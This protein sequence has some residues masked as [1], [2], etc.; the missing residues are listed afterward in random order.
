[1]Y[2]IIII[3]T[4]QVHGIQTKKIKQIKT[5][6][7]FFSHEPVGTKQVCITSNNYKELLT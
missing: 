5:K 4:L 6:Y 1:M 7:S 3:F 2:L